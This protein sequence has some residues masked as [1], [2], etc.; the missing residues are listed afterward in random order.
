MTP[1]V[2]LYDRAGFEIVNVSKGAAKVQCQGVGEI[3]CT[4][5]LGLLNVHL[6]P[7]C[8][9]NTTG[10]LHVVGRQRVFHANCRDR[11]FAAIVNAGCVASKGRHRDVGRAAINAVGL[12]LGCGVVVIESE[13]QSISDVPLD[14]DAE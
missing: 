13:S 10:D 6:C 2:T 4:R 3:E 8:A 12:T 5:E 7:A 1:G 9:K 11:N 14:V